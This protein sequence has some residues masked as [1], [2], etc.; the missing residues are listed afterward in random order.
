MCIHLKDK[1]ELKVAESDIGLWKAVSLSDDGS[2]WRGAWRKNEKAFPFGEVAR[3]TGELEEFHGH[4]IAFAGFF[5]SVDD[6]E[7]A[8]SIAG[9]LHF[10]FGWRGYA[11]RCTIPAGALYCSDSLGEYASDRIVVERPE[12]KEGAS[13]V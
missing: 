5:H 13:C 1:S 2:G 3:E 12:R 9:A 10:A 7:L 11:V 8:E 6:R 4:S